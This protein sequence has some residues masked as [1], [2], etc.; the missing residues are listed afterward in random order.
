MPEV[1]KNEQ[2]VFVNGTVNN[3]NEYAG[4]SGISYTL[5]VAILG[6]RSMLPVRV[7]PEMYHR[8]VLGDDFV[9]RIEIQEFKWGT[10]FAVV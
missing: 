10:V 4:K 8:A 5:D 7:P 2:G 6:Q 3:K 1:K 9:H